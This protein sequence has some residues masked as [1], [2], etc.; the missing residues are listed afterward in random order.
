MNIKGQVNQ[1]KL[2][3]AKALWPLFETIVNS[4]QSIEDTTKCV[5]PNVTVI[6]NRCNF[7]QLRINDSPEQG[8]FTDFV[9]IDNGEGFTERNYNSFLEAYSTYKVAKGCKGI[10]RFLW[11]K[12][13]ERVDIKSVY[14]ENGQWYIRE[15]SFSLD[16]IID[17]ENNKRP[18][19]DSIDHVRET[20]I[21]LVGFKSDYRDAIPLSLESLVKRIIEHCLPYFLLNICPNIVVKASDGENY[22]LNKY[23]KNTYK[24]TLHQDDF[25]IKDKSFSL[26][27]MMVNEGADHHELHLCANNREVKSYDLSKFIP[28]LSKKISSDDAS[29]YY[30]GYMTGDFLDESV[31]SDRYEFSFKDEPLLET[32]NE[33]ELLDTAVGFVSAYL[34]VDLGRIDE[35]KKQQIDRFVK[36]K[37]P[38]YRFMLNTRRDVYDKI[39]PGLSEDKLDIELYKQE[40]E[41]ELDL[42]KRKN[43]IESRN[44]TDSVNSSEFM[45]LFEDYCSNVTQLSQASLAEYIV[46]RKAVIDLLAKALEINESGK[47]SKEARVHSIICPMRITSDDVKFEEMNLWLIDDRLAYHQFLASDK[48]MKSLPVIDSNED[49]RMDIAIFDKALSYSSDSDDIN[50]ITIVELKKPQRNDLANDDNNPINQV[51]D[52]VAS[53]KSGTVTQSNGRGFGG[54]IRNAAFYCYVIADL[55]SSLINA[56]ENAGLYKTPDGEGYYG[57][58]SARGAYIEVIS[59]NKLLKDAKKRN[60]VL[61]DKLFNPKAN[62][63]LMLSPE[64]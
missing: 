9:V 2:P 28:N 61:F 57:F 14:T 4:I 22:N 1:I 32:V 10:G 18:L 5:S 27:H 46:R 12:A 50:S 39:P 15:F 55:T 31:N 37:K 59:Y 23:Y 20:T 3:K 44:D 53:I 26:Y 48:P 11:L 30:V 24:D 62:Q 7:Q 60:Q 19:D 42:A 17:P 47:Y 34:S 6:A 64:Q 40:Q 51:L 13:F 33:K 38:Q 21:H 56:A 35:E 49:K 43:E 29:F 45:D 41:W 36:Y 16:R 54:N 8:H 52:Y 25:T 63:L 58:N